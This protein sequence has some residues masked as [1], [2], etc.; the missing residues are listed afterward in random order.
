MKEMRMWIMY[1]K[2]DNPEILVSFY[3]DKKFSWKMNS[4]L[5]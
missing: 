4:E 5:E 2:D 3:V 1:Q